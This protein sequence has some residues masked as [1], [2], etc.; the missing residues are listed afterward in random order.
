MWVLAP[1][2]VIVLIAVLLD[3]WLAPESPTRR[4]TREWLAQ[5]RRALKGRGV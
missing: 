1:L 5:R 2:G 4:E 3:K